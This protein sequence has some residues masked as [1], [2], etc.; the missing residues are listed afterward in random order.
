MRFAN[1]AFLWLLLALP[2]MAAYAAWFRE[3]DLP[4]F[5][6]SSV[7]SVPNVT[8]KGR[9]LIGTIVLSALRMLAFLLL[10]IALARPQ[11]GLRSEEMTT[12][13][14]DIMVVL[15]ASRSMM[16]ID[17]KP[18]NRFEVARNVIK[19]FIAG[20]PHDRLGLVVFAEYA[21]TQCPL[22]TDKSALLEI[23][24]TVQI[25]TIPPD[26]TAVGTGLATAV[27]RLKNSQARSKVVILVTD[28]A[29]NAGS[30][31][32]LT[33]AKTAEAFG[34]KIH[35]IGAGTPEGGLM[36]I[37]DPLMGRRMVPIKSD[38]DEDTLL[39][40]AT[41]TGGK[42]FRARTEGS[43]KTIFSEIDS[44]EKT[45]IKVKEYVDYQELYLGWILAAIAFLFLEL[46]LAKTAFRTLP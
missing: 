42:Y 4:T 22:T 26:Q 29:N 20:R 40:V 33:A 38:L 41:V 15:D 12:R 18:D 46:S 16:A 30:V 7:D 31:D 32:P 34:I 43:L 1:P 5:R 14:T 27:N 25:G 23:L 37:D 24:S 44:L 17:F 10:V 45:D 36:P 6:F 11:R 3:R 9:P 8:R 13:A 19:E 21:V 2:L 28:G 35:T 39:K